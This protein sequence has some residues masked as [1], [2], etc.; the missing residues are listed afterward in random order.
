[1]KKPLILLLLFVLLGAAGCGLLGQARELT[2]NQTWAASAESYD[3]VVKA[4]TALGN[5]GVLD[6]DTLVEFDK[7]RRKAR[8]AL[9]DWRDALLSG[10]SDAV[11]IAIKVFNGAYA[12]LSDLKTAGEAK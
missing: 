1:M 10:Q 3:T 2:P 11:Q 9:D 12:D 6:Y 5:E 4:I 7:Y 8:K